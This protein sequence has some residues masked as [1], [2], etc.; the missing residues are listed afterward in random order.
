VLLEANE[1]LIV[2]N[3]RKR[4]SKLYSHK[5]IQQL[6]LI[7]RK[8]SVKISK[9]LNVPISIYKMTFSDIDVMDI[10]ELI[11]KEGNHESLT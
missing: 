5:S 11:T 6:A 10:Y 9:E 7:E 2:E 3:L 4:D 1:D 8:Q